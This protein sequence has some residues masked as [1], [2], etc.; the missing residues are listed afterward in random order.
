M[1]KDIQALRAFAVLS[2][3]A[4]HAGLP[5]LDAGYLG[6]DMFFV[7]SGYLIIGMLARELSETGRIRLVPFFARRARR[8]LPAA[9]L[10][11][12]A[13][14][15]MTVLVMPGLQGQRVFEDVEAAAFYVANLHF[16]LIQMD[17]W[18]P[19]MVSPVIHFWSLGVEEQFYVLFP[20]IL[21]LTALLGRKVKNLTLVLIVQL[22]LI[23]LA[24]LVFML[25]QKHIATAW[26]F[27]SPLCRAWEF[28]I[29][30]LAVLLGTYIGSRQQKL[31]LALCAVSSVGVVGLVLGDKFLSF[32]TT[33]NQVLA[34][35]IVGVLLLTGSA[36]QQDPNLLEKIFAIKPLQW[37]GN[38]SYSIYLWH[39]PALYFGANFFRSGTFR[40]DWLSYQQRIILILCTFVL[41]YFSYRFVENPLRKHSR[42]VS[43]SRNSLL[44]G[45]AFSVGVAGL[46]WSAS[47]FA[48]GR[49]STSPIV[50]VTNAQAVQIIN[51]QQVT[52]AISRLSPSTLGTDESAISHKQLDDAAGGLP[53]KETSHC[54]AQDLKGNL[55]Q[56]CYFGNSTQGSVIALVGSSHAYQFYSPMLAVADAANSRL[57][58]ETRGGCAIL[59]GLNFLAED[60]DTSSPK[61]C[62]TWQRKVITHL[63]ET[64]PAVIV[65]VTGRSRPVDPLTGKEASASRKMTLTS[66]AL[67]DLVKELE[68][69][70]SKLVFIRETPMLTYDPVICLSAHTVSSCRQPLS[71]ALLPRKMSLPQADVNRVV[72]MDLSLAMCDVKI[73][74]A[75]RHG[76]IVWRDR[77]H[78]TNQYAQALSPLFLE[79]FRPIVQTATR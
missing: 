70:K 49:I 73:C 40:P 76:M 20:L 31:R 74:P 54:L 79:L 57:L 68:P 22:S 50:D 12:V 9:S 2:V 41:A 21:A 29:G 53:P 3:V 67:A 13:T 16:A 63:I 46:A 18:Q 1:R 65:I 45:L 19:V 15:L 38:L 11:L 47:Q 33:T 60:A 14:V 43:S 26:S 25:Q 64:K 34:T 75:V 78:I 24:S 77:H 37:I 66:K 71:S 35:S 42:L 4:F 8:L 17:Y 28:A 27:Y 39:W 62:V 52:N 55:P 56:N 69:T 72:T 23:G 51:T 58:L 7:I 5:G 61:S 6:V 36:T 30:G 48:P 59:P 10:V 44:M 32:T